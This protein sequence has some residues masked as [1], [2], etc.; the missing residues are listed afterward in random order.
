MYKYNEFEKCEFFTHHD[1]F[2][3]DNERII[4]KAKEKKGVSV[5]DVVALININWKEVISN[6]RYIIHLQGRRL[7]SIN[8]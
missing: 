2:K 7:V 4:I 3:P 5:A 8:K 6:V 1:R